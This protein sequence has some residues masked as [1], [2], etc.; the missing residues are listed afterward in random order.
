MV[1]N[2]A[3]SRPSAVVAACS[4]P[5]QFLPF[6]IDS[7]ACGGICIGDHERHGRTKLKKGSSPLQGAFTARESAACASLLPPLPYLACAAVGALACGEATQ[8]K[9][10]G[11][12]ARNGTRAGGAGLLV[13]ELRESGDDRRGCTSG[14]LQ[15]S[16]LQR[17]YTLSCL[18]LLLASAIKAGRDKAGQGKESEHKLLQ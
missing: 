5:V 10:R 1:G 2:I 14:F 3:F 6:F 17:T 15:R 9:W 16:P 12:Q 8:G 7:A 11:R 18:D 13:G 4:F